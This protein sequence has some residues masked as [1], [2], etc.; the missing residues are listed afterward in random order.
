MTAHFKSN[1]NSLQKMDEVI[2]RF[3]MIAKDILEN[4][5]NITLT[6]SRGVSKLWCHFIDDQK[7]PWLRR[8]RVHIK[9]N[10][11]FL[12]DWKKMIVKAPVKVVKELAYATEKIFTLK[13]TQLWTMT[14]DR[15][16][17][18]KNGPWKYS[19]KIWAVTTTYNKNVPL[20]PLT[21]EPYGTFFYLQDEKTDNILTV[22]KV[23]Y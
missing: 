8:I 2:H 9:S 7:T 23:I 11:Q 14:S 12:D 20:F 21:W 5:N 15:K 22:A 18:N 17:L 13:D 3:P 1:K 16:L 4:L 19:E 10:N 6:E